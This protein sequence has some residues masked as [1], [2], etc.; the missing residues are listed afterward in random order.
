MSHTSKKS[1]LPPLSAALL[2]AL[3]LCAWPAA[4]RQ[5][6]Q[7]PQDTARFITFEYDPCI[8]PDRYRTAG[9]Q[10]QLDT[11]S[12]RRLAQDNIMVHAT[13]GVA[14]VP[15]TAGLRRGGDLPRDTPCS[16][17]L[18]HCAAFGSVETSLMQYNQVLDPPV[19]REDPELKRST[20]VA[21]LA[22]GLRLDFPHTRGPG[23]GPWFLQFK[24]TRRTPGFRA[25]IPVPRHT[26]AAV[27][28][29]TEF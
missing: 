7:P 4:A 13:A 23:H 28:L 2:A 14:R 19:F 11:A 17:P 25:S 8:D 20:L 12:C 22:L 18:L 3:G 21:A 15:G 29:G 26:S 10:L 27:A 5:A 1:G 9:P 24:I 6:D 16:T